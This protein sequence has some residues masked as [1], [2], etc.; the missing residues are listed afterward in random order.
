MMR[1]RLTIARWLGLTAIIAV[2]LALFR[3]LG[4]RRVIV[5]GDL[6]LVALQV[7][8]WC[9][10]RSGWR[11]RRFWAGFVVPNMAAVL[12]LLLC[13]PP[14]VD[15]LMT[16]FTDVADEFEVTYLPASLS[17][18]L[19]DELWDLHLAVVYFVPVFIAALLGGMIAARLLPGG[20]TPA[21]TMN[22][23]EST[24]LIG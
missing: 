6:I 23:E 16:P 8:L 21:R 22:R 19:G 17:G 1:H 14:L 15:R 18:S 24:A 7:G 13:P 10:L 2:Y 4:D 9:L 11:L 20:L 12:A 5:G 3:G